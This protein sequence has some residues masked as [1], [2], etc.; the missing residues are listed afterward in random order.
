LARVFEAMPPAAAAARIAPLSDDV[1]L[2]IALRMRARSLAAVITAMPPPEAKRL[3]EAMAS[4]GADRIEAA[5]QTVTAG[6]AEG[7]PASGG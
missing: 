4:Q 2:A 7:W 6:A 1:R 3:A 5:R